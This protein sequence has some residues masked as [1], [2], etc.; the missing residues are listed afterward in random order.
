MVQVAHHRE[1]TGDEAGTIAVVKAAEQHFLEVLET[2]ALRH[3]SSGPRERALARTKIQEA[4]FW[5]VKS[6]TG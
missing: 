2:A 3:P 4:A 6:I 5:A 1:L